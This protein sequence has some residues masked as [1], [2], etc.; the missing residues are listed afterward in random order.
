MKMRRWFFSIVMILFIGFSIQPMLAEANSGHHHEPAVIK[1]PNIPKTGE[2]SAL[3]KLID[4]TEPGGTLLLEGR[5]YRGSMS[6]T[7]PITIKG[8]EGTEV[9]SLADTFII[10]EVENISLQNMVIQSEG[11]AILANDM[12]SL[13]VKDVTIKDSAAGIQITNSENIV[14][15]NVEIIGRAGHFSTKNHGV[16]IYDSKN[17]LVAGNSINQ[18]MD[19]FYVENVEQINLTNNEIKNSRY[20][21][22]MMYS[23]HVQISKNK[24]TSNMTGFMVM[25]AKDVTIEDNVVMKNNSL[26]SL[27]VY[28]YDVE[29]VHFANNELRENTIAMDIQNAKEMVVENNHFSAN[30]TVLQVRR[31][32]TLVVQNNEFHGNILSART[33]KAGV[34]LRSNFYDDYKGKD[35][36]GDGIGDTP[37]I[38]TN[39][40]GQWMVRKPVYQYFI[41]SPSVVTLNM[42]D[43]EVGGGKGLVIADEEPMLF[44]QTL[45]L[46]VDINSWQLLMST[47]VLIGMFMV[48]RRLR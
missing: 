24:V 45:N 48:R 6:I 22:H 38:A 2:K 30:G 40:F 4:A 47:V 19:G 33:D 23:D 35:Y 34:I 5:V 16:A 14:L 15:Q 28:T 27:G 36:D 44:K 37:Y 29:N 41:E 3:Q 42:M 43:T 20:A 21:V 46:K 7:K 1:K 9:H 10:S 8:V 39:S 17:V 13:E 26:N 11:I 25:I 31:S 32:P 12:K 18:V